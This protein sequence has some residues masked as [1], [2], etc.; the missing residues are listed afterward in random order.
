MS[1]SSDE[2]SYSSNMEIMI[3]CVSQEV[4]VQQPVAPTRKKV[5]PRPEETGNIL[6]KPWRNL[7]PDAW[8]HQVKRDKSKI[9]SND[10]F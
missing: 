1:D 9:V 3:F 10:F 4:T 5:Y 2:V 6:S 8:S 7:G